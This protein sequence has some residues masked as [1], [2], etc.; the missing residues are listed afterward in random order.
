MTQARAIVRRY[1]F[2]STGLLLLGLGIVGAFVP[3]MPSSIFLLGAVWCF[4]RSSPRLEAW[5]LDHPQLGPPLRLWIEHRALTR[6]M[7]IG[8]AIAIVAGFAIFVVSAHPSP[9]VCGA[10]ASFFVVCTVWIWRRPE[11]PA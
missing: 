6:R 3:L 11:P 8:A 7:K 10:V 1:L 4:A 5:V 2:L 9:L